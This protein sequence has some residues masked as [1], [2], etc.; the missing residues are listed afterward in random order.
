MLVRPEEWNNSPAPASC[1]P[2]RIWGR[3]TNLLTWGVRQESSAP[4]EAKQFMC[5][6]YYY[7]YSS[8]IQTSP[9]FSAQNPSNSCVTTTTTTTTTTAHRFKQVLDSLHRSQAIYVLLLLLLQLT[10]SNKSLILCPVLVH[11][12]YRLFM[13][14]VKPQVARFITKLRATVIA[15][16][17]PLFF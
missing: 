4:T 6:Y 13:F 1:K 11:A 17:G 16:H 3:K 2:L 5:Y 14:R 8:Q 12:S 15:S 10:D 7:Y 9:W